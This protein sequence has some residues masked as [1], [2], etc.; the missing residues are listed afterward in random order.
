MKRRLS[1]LL[2]ILS[3]IPLLFINT[4]GS[5]KTIDDYVA[6]SNMDLS[7]YKAYQF[8][9]IFI[10][11]RMLNGISYKMVNYP[12]I[13]NLLDG[14]YHITISIDNDMKLEIY[15]Y[16]KDNKGLYLY[17][18]IDEDVFLLITPDNVESTSLDLRKYDSIFKID[19]NNMR[20]DG[21]NKEQFFSFMDYMGFEYVNTLLIKE[22]KYD[23]IYYI[24]NAKSLDELNNTNYSENQYDFMI[25][26]YDSNNVGTYEFYSCHL[27]SEGV[28]YINHYI[29]RIYDSTSIICD[30]ITVSY[31][32]PMNMNEYRNNHIHGY[33]M[34]FN[35][36][37]YVLYSDYFYGKSSILGNYPVTFYYKNDDIEFESEGMISVVDDIPPII[38]GNT[39]VINDKLSKKAVDIFEVLKDYE[40]FD[41]IDGDLTD[42]I[43]IT[44]LDNY[45]DELNKGGTFRFLILCEDNSGNEAKKTIKYIIEDDIPHEEP[46][47]TIEPTTTEN[48]E[49]N[50]TS[51]I[52]STSDQI[53][54]EYTLRCNANNP[55]DM[56]GL[57]KK[58]I[59]YGLIDE[60]YDGEIISDYFGNESVNGE[61]QILVNNNGKHYY[62]L[63]VEGNKEDTKDDLENKNDNL[64]II[65]VLSSVGGI[66]IIIIAIM[67]I[68]IIKKKLNK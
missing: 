52:V 29:I 64:I 65:I 2:I 34:D 20:T 30:D 59:F 36:N 23:E 43:R 40:A 32:N 48:T 44:N 3:F 50:I 42:R 39:T 62:S 19:F 66:L 12:S 28:L 24:D 54:I 11:D 22:K 5:S 33:N 27:I 56:D 49:N 16:V 13:D 67:L 7:I 1:I 10:N 55:L 6:E 47:K 9:Y 53:I 41:E 38:K 8:N 61:Y 51:S 57:R 58:L 45:S 21:I 46:V 25:G 4:K 14:E 26:G 15:Y 17:F 18:V 68:F 63:I 60:D 35:I 31:K 37:E